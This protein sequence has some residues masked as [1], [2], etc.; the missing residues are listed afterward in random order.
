MVRENR[1]RVEIAGQRCESRWA[2]LGASRNYAFGFFIASAIVLAILTGKQHCLWYFAQKSCWTPPALVISSDDWGE[3]SPL[4]TVADLDKLQETLS[5]VTDA[6]GRPLVLTTYL[7]PAE[8]NF[9]EIAEKQYTGYSWRYCYRDKPEVAARLRELHEAGLVDI[10]FHGREHS[11]IPLW[12]SVLQENRPGFRQACRDH[13]IPGRKEP[14][15]QGSDDPRRR[16][17]GASFVDASAYPARALPVE[18]QREMI[19]SGL[20]L[21][22]AK[23][24]VRATIVTAP[25][26]VFDTNTLH[27][28][29]LDGL[30]FL[31]SIERPIRL[32]DADGKVVQS[33]RRWDYGVE[34]T[35]VRGIVRNVNFEPARTRM[36]PQ[37]YL[38]VTM[39][40][41]HRALVSRE[42]IVVCSHRWNFVEAANPNLNRDL[43]LLR[44]LVARTKAEAPDVMFLGAADLARHLYLGGA[45]AERDVKLQARQLSTMERVMHGVRCTWVG[46]SQVRLAASAAGLSLVWLCFAG[47][48]RSRFHGAQDVDSSEQT[49]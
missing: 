29:A 28:M 9:E 1:R 5:S 48:L 32:A 16:F 13:R 24:G 6:S 47:S 37:K 17:I 36:A 2:R 43:L 15:W 25:S 12:L 14:E 41:V 3:T 45:G 42:P 4:E 44:E 49:A 20:A 39:Q 34:I 38:E 19:A 22:E 23:L 31:D 26:Y 46:H 10:E 18:Q 30:W 11:N 33:G 21:M 7:C 40:A 35:G 8:P 27:A